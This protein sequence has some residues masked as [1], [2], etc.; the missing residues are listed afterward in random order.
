MK[1]LNIYTPVDE[2][3]ERVPIAFIRKIQAKLKERPVDTTVG[4]ASGNALLMDT[5][6]SYPVTFPFNP[7]N[8]TL[9]TLAVPENLHLGFLVRH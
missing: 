1:I 5:K 6:Y 8:V 7:S 2:F 3:E 9:D 4:G